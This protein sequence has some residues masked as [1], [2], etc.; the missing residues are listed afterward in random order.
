MKHATSK[1]RV[2]FY[3]T[4]RGDQRACWAG[5]VPVG[6]PMAELKVNMP[7]GL[8]RTGMSCGEFAARVGRIL[9]WTVKE[10]S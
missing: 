1:R 5:A 10:E 2:V 8:K 4:G 3:V 9:V 7:R 6:R